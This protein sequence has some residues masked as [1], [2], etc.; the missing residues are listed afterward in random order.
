MTAI[1]DHPA[2][3][4]SSNPRTI[5]VVCVKDGYT[6]NFKD[7]GGAPTRD[8]FQPHPFRSQLER[9]MRQTDRGLPVYVVKT[10]L[11]PLFP[12]DPLA[13]FPVLS[14]A[15]EARITENV[16]VRNAHSIADRA[17]LVQEAKK[18]GA[19]EYVQKLVEAAAAQQIADAGKGKKADK[20]A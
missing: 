13:S 2:A 8:G 3:K 17:L 20:G 19:S 15:I 6:Y 4:L 1:A 10:A 14:P 11:A 7:D 12:S 5:E 16:R 9:K 18:Q